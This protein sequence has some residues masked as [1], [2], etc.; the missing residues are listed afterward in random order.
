MAFKDKGW[1]IHNG[2][3][4]VQILDNKIHEC[5]AELGD[6]LILDA[7]ASYISDFCHDE[8]LIL[9][10]IVLDRISTAQAEMWGDI[11]FSRTDPHTK[12]YIEVRW[13]DSQT[14]M[15]HIVCNP[16]HV[17]CITTKVPLAYNTIF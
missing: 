9:W 8:N 7:E 4:F 16:E 6:D 2:E 14:K 13:Y 12:E 5:V 10:V 15:K 17:F 11:S 1:V 3:K